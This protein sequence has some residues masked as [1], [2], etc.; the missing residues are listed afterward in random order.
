M[1]EILSNLIVLIV[2]VAGF[3]GL[4][5]WVRRDAFSTSLAQRTLTRVI[6][7]LRPERYESQAT[8]ATA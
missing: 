1:S 5:G 2:L 3:A 4:V 6:A 7:D 8:T